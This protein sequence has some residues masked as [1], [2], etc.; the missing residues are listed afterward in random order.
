MSNAT[1]TDV[2]DT[3]APVHSSK[4]SCCGGEPAPELRTDTSALAGQR[5]GHSEP[6]HHVHETPSA[7]AGSC[8]CGG[9][10]S[11]SRPAGPK[12]SSIKSK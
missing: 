11:D 6:H 10:A 7:P 2:K 12:G 4:H 1:T 8:C 9:V 3:T 5:G